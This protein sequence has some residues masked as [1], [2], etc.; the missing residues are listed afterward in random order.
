MKVGEILTMH[1]K[2]SWEI[3]NL[4]AKS[5]WFCSCCSDRRGGGC[6]CEYVVPRGIDSRSGG[7]MGQALLSCDHGGDGLHLI[8]RGGD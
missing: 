5:S 1:V 8:K 7:G 6:M 3:K 4:W 2:R